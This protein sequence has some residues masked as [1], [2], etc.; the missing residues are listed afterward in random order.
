VIQVVV[1]GAR[2]PAKLQ[3]S[4]RNWAKTWRGVEAKEGPESLIERPERS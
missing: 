1:W 4:Q 3:A 2:P